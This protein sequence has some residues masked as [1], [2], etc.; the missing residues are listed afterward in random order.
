MTS[1]LPK[2][3]SILD[4]TIAYENNVKPTM[5][6]AFSGSC[7]KTVHIHIKKVDNPPN[8]EEEFKKWLTEKYQDKDKLLDKFRE[9]NKF[10]DK[11]DYE[12]KLDSSVYFSLIFW[13]LWT[14]FITY[15]TFFVH[16]YFLPFQYV[17]IVLYGSVGFSHKLRVFFWTITKQRKG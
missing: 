3:T 1:S 5:W 10:P 6:S 8:E 17:G 14:I 13:M 4:L 2:T 16:D 15:L 11:I 12:F 9:T 7:P